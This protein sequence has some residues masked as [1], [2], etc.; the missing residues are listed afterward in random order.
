MRRSI[1]PKLALVPGALIGQDAAA[2]PGA[3]SV[4]NHEFDSQLPSLASLVRGRLNG[5]AVPYLLENILPAGS[6]FD[7]Y[8]LVSASFCLSQTMLDITQVD[9]TTLRHI[10]ESAQLSTGDVLSL[11]I[12]SFSIIPDPTGAYRTKWIVKDCS[13]AKKVADGLIE[14]ACRG[15]LGIFTRAKSFGDVHVNVGTVGIDC[16]GRIH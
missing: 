1:L 11:K 13:T 15:D 5:K 4:D 2:T 8:L 16:I 3:K 7:E 14:C 6:S 12:S 10:A 9:D